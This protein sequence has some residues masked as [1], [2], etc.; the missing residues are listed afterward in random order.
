[1]K[2]HYLSSKMRCPTCNERK[3]V[4]TGEKRMIVAGE[5]CSHEL[6]CL[7]G[8]VWWD[9]SRRASMMPRTMRAY[10]PR[11]IVPWE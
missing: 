8:H 3:I 2:A 5:A 6:R 11:R 9:N 7:Q 4:R 1:M 10:E